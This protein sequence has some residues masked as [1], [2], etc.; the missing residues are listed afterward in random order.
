M[1]KT[2]SYH[3]LNEELEIV[4]WKGDKKIRKIDTADN[5]ETY[6]VRCRE[7]GWSY[8][9]YQKDFYQPFSYERLE[10]LKNKY[11]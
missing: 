9:I 8:R 3:A 10:E 5:I 6:K 4:A 11:K 7:L 2:K 1:A